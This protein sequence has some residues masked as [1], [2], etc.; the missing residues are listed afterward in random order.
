MPAIA[1]P[2]AAARP[3][4]MA[5][6]VIRPAQ[7]DTVLTTLLPP[8]SGTAA[9]RRR[10]WMVAGAHTA[11]YS[12]TLVLLNEAWYKRYPKTSFQ[13]F[14]DSREWL[15][16]DK[17]GHTWTAYQLSRLSMASW[18]WAGLS[19]K[20]QVWLGG[21]SGFTFQTV[22]EVLDAHSAEWGWSW[23]DIAANTFGS[24][25]LIG[26]E[27]AWGEQRISFKFGFHRVQYP[28]GLQER[29]ANDLFGA[30]LP[31]RMLKDY[32]G[33]T[34]WL[35]ANL[36]SFFKNSHLP[37]WLNLAVGYG[38]GGMLGGFTNQWTDPPTNLPV[39]LSSTVPRL[40]QWYIAPDIDFTRI[41]TRNKFLRSVFFCL[42][43]FKLPSPTLALTN[44][45]LRVYGLYF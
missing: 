10:V 30:S 2:P 40:R 24:G 15:Q 3:D 29:R 18:R 20:Q 16:V 25:M 32:N 17:V 36:R 12:G 45:K 26:Q 14:N 35:S 34:Y 9:N 27:L 7:L 6:E 38:A 44:G 8:D 41:K 19:K 42:N 5:L 23:A 33:Q 13:V 11:L 43:A 31:E 4:T 39:D 22:I 1:Q 37:P 28:Q 21:L